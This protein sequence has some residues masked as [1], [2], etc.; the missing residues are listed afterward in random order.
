MIKFSVI[1][2]NIG[3]KNY[4]K[5]LTNIEKKLFKINKKTKTST[6]HSSVL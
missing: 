1:L 3:W 5:N 6:K 2:N 4:L